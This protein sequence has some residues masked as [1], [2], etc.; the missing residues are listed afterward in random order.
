MPRHRAQKGVRPTE[1]GLTALSPL[2]LYRGPTE[3]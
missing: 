2:P 1:A 3:Q